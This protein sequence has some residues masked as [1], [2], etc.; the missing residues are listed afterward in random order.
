MPQTRRPSHHGDYANTS[1]N[2]EFST[3]KTYDK[4]DPLAVSPRFKAPTRRPSSLIS[5]QSLTVDA[6]DAS[7][8]TRCAAGS[9]RERGQEE[10]NPLREEMQFLTPK[11]TTGPETPLEE[12]GVVADPKDELD[13]I[14]SAVQ[15]Y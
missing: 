4:E 3:L 15:Q 2:T 5:P 11:A 13:K 6:L 10:A 14:T 7:S 8:E 1:P 9:I 12:T